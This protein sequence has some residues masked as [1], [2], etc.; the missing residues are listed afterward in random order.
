MRRR[1]GAAPATSPS[2]LTCPLTPRWTPMTTRISVVLPPPRPPA[3]PPDLSAPPPLDA[4]DDAHQRRL[5]PA[6]R[7][8]QAG[9]APAGQLEREAVQHLSPAP[10]HPK[11][12]RRYRRLIIHRLMILSPESGAHRNGRARSSAHRVPPE[13]RPDIWPVL[14]ECPPARRGS[15]SSSPT[16]SPGAAWPSSPGL[17]PSRCSS[18][19]RSSRT[20]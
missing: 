17:R 6:A 7:P 4:D 18:R 3:V 5:A 14:Q 20:L 2:T 8:D 11:V 9:D 15:A 19:S 12:A 10:A 13:K 16:T 1:S